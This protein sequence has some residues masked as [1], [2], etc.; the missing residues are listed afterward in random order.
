[1]QPLVNTVEEMTKLPQLAERNMIVSAGA[2]RMADNPI[3]MSGLAESTTRR[4]APAL[5]ADTD[6][7]RAEFAPARNSKS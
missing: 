6:R 5:G 7:I 3:K 2:I 4:A 1:V